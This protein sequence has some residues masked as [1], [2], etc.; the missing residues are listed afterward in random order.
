MFFVELREVSREHRWARE[1]EVNAL[2]EIVWTSIG[3]REFQYCM[4]FGGRRG[5]WSLRSFAKLP[6]NQTRKIKGFFAAAIARHTISLKSRPG[7]DLMSSAV[8]A[9]IRSSMAKR[10][11]YCNRGA[12]P[13]AASDRGL[14]VEPRL[15]RTRRKFPH[16]LVVGARNSCDLG[17]ARFR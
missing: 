4:A 2:L 3:S 12:W 15:P 16:L 13:A 9:I 5:N 14:G 7:A 6:E 1:G 8:S 11:I 10:F 17:P